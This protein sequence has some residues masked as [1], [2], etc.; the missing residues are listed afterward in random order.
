MRSPDRQTLDKNLT[1]E[2]GQLHGK[3]LE[4]RGKWRL[5]GQQNR[6]VDKLVSEITLQVSD[7]SEL[8]VMIGEKCKMVQIKSLY[9]LDRVCSSGGLSFRI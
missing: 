4:K 7:R 9:E 5:A 8:G 2:Q 3:L 6:K 1:G